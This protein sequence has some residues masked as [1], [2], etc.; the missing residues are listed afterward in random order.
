MGHLLRRFPLAL[1]WE[2]R[3][4]VSGARRAGFTSIASD[5]RRGVNAGKADSRNETGAR[6]Q[7]TRELVAIR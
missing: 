5:D 6:R 3:G 7:E 2:C 4:S 1:P